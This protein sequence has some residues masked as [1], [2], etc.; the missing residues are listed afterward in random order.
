MFS[1]IKEVGY[2]IIAGVVA[3]G[4]VVWYLITQGK[5]IQRDNDRKKRDK[6]KKDIRKEKGKTKKKVRGMSDED[7]DNII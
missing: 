4:F 2:K 7:L 1:F 6:K 3:I 5:I